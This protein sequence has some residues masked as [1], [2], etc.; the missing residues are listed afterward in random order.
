MKSLRNA[1]SIEIENTIRNKLKITPNISADQIFTDATIIRTIISKLPK[2]NAQNQRR[3][4]PKTMR[5]LN[6]KISSDIGVTT[7]KFMV[8]ACSVKIPTKINICP[9]IAISKIINVKKLKPT[10]APFTS[11]STVC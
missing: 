11:T 8:E 1:K 2:R 4:R 6:K 5:A 10:D 3:L 9:T 7:K